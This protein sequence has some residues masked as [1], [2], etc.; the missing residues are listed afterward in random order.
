MAT[1]LV[2]LAVN[3]ASNLLT[4]PA[5]N[6]SDGTIYAIQNKGPGNVALSVAA[7]APDPDTAPA[8]VL[9]PLSTYSI[10]T[11]V[12]QPIYAWSISVPSTIVITE[13]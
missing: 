2:S 9:L 8:F 5:T 11:D 12:A 6:L 3:V 10:T 13:G 1:Q 4:A 7:S